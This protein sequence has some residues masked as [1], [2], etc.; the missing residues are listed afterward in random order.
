MAEIA[1]VRKS[2]A[3]HGYNIERHQNNTNLRKYSYEHCLSK[4]IVID[5][6]VTNTTFKNN[7]LRS[8]VMYYLVNAQ[9][10]QNEKEIV[11]HFLKFNTN[12]D[13]HKEIQS[14]AE[15]TLKLTSGNKIPNVLLVNTDNTVNELHSY[16]KR[17]TVLYFWSS[18][19][20]KHYKD[21]HSKVAALNSKFPNYD[22]IGINT[23]THFKKWREIVINTGYN[24]NLEF[25]LE[26]LK[27][28]EKKLVINSMNKAIIIDD[29][30]IILENNTNLFGKT[31]DKHLS[32]YSN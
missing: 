4:V 24:K 6:L 9:D 17:P 3:R 26:N 16:V 20:V 22:F 8:C 11:A 13:H 2:R 15:A 7:L 29:S 5:S 28:A 32:E 12:K 10:A 31:I 21:I 1:C 14:L 23:D 25:Q 19:S 18:K 27:E 30:S